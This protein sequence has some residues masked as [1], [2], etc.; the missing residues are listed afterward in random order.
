MIEKIAT[1]PLVDRMAAALGD[2]SAPDAD[3]GPA[4]LAVSG[5]WGSSAPILAALLAWR[6]GRPLLYLAAHDDDADRA[7]DDIEA[8]FGRAPTLL[9]AL[10]SGGAA[11]ES[12]AGSV[13]AA[14]RARICAALGARQHPAREA[15]PKENPFR[16]GEERHPPAGA[17]AAEPWVVAPLLA[18]M[19]PVPTRAALE[20]H[21]LA[22]WPGRKLTPGELSEWL[23]ARGQERLDQVEE[24][25][26]FAVRGG[27]IDIFSSPDE[28]PLRIEFVDDAI[29]SV[30]QFDVGSQRSMRTL[31]RAVVALSPATERLTPDQTTSFLDLLPPRTVVAICEPAEVDETGRRILQRLATPVGHFAA[32]AVLER[33]ARFAAVHLSRFAGGTAPAERTFSAACEALPAFEPKAVDA[34]QQLVTLAAENDTIVFCDNPG[35]AERLRELVAQ[36][37]AA[38][39]DAAPLTTVSRPWRPAEIGIPIG[40]LHQGFRWR[41]PEGVGSRSLVVL[42]DRELFHRYQQTR[43]IRRVV[44]GR[45]IDSFLDLQPGDLVV[46]VVYGIARFGGM[47]TMHKGGSRQAEE[48]LTLRFAEGATVHVPVS[49]I[50]LVQK[51]IGAGGARPPLSKLGGARWK[52]TT[53]RVEEAVGDLAAELL[54]IQAERESRPGTA[55]PADTAWQGEFERSFPYPE[56]PDQTAALAEIKRDLVRER[57]MDRLL[58]GDV[59]YGKTELAIRAAFKVVEYGR[60]AAILVPTTVLAEQ[61]ERTCRERLA[62]YPF[63]IESLS[64]FRSPREQADILARARKGQVDI[65]IGTHRLLSRDVQFADLGL[66]VIDEEQR[67]GVEHKERLKQLRSTV[68]VLTLTAT[69]IPRTLHLSLIGL[70][71]ISALATPPM[72]RRSIATRVV[73]WNDSL[74]REAILREMNRDGQVY[75]VHNRVHSIEATAARIAR[76]VPE[77][78]LLVGHGQMAGN[79][80]EQVMLRFVQREADVLVCTTIIEAGLDIPNVNTILIDRAD[81]FGLADLHQLRGRVGRYKHRAYCYLLLSPDRPLTETA[82]RRLKTV[83]EFS[84]LGAGF[85]IAMRDLEIRG[86]GNI[87]GPQQSGHIAA[88]GYEMFCRLLESAVRRMKGEPAPPVIDVHLELNVEAHLPRH[89]IPSDRQRM[90]AYRRLTACR[91]PQDVARL[92]ADL[93]DAFGRLPDQ[94]RMVVALAELRTLAAPWSIRAIVRR[95][96]DLIFTVDDLK[97]V[98]PL[99]AGASGSVRLVD[100]RTIHWRL[101]DPYFHAQTLLTV[102]RNQFVRAAQSMRAGRS[103]AP[104]HAAG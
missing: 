50:D 34:V 36:V 64:R 24:P 99:F 27:I 60:Q 100:Q 73:A 35:E 82:A 37:I 62:D 2:G 8:V 51:Y 39:P 59:G 12:P 32:R 31:E 91:T 47:K 80:L 22:L 38:A 16:A 20:A 19:Q 68:D 15:P 81:T 97:R 9:P 69:P 84:E 94:A 98:E 44:S 57:P 75:F 90:E 72:D 71:D 11:G 4:P 102:L 26:D 58:C 104:R 17:D 48:Y 66:V 6:T 53:A 43:R 5:L 101:P 86:A 41:L 83:E 87:L 93:G 65:L 79:A 63:T 77:A 10:E 96:P 18:L 61:H 30:R 21:S 54:R 1:D 23:V 92:E 28:D 70:R 56:T 103:P 89:Y 42:T 33:A 55:Y 14:E 49:Q 7:R 95:E 88:V 74:V 25:G 29:E 85:Q 3:R 46:H 40:P 13:N 52:A 67:F 45:P 76:I 78:R